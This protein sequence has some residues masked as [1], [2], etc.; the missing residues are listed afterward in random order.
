VATGGVVWYFFFRK[1]KQESHTCVSPSKSAAEMIAHQASNLYMGNDLLLR[2]DEVVMEPKPIANGGGGQ[3]FLGQFGTRKVALKENFASLGC[4]ATLDDQKETIREAGLL[5]KLRHPNVVTF[6]G[7]WSPDRNTGDNDTSGLGARV[8]LVLEYCENGDLT[9]QIQNTETS[10]ELRRK[11][12]FQIAD[13]LRFLHDREPPIVHRDIKPGNILLDINNNAKVADFGTSKQQ[14]ERDLT[15]CVG[16]IA[17]M[18]PEILAD[19]SD[20]DDDKMKTVADGTK[21]DVF[22][23]AV[24]VTYILSGRRPHEGKN[25]KQIFLMV[26][27]RNE[28]TPIPEEIKDDSIVDLIQRMWHDQP[29]KRPSFQQIVEELKVMNFQVSPAPA[30]GNDSEETGDHTM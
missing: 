1:T 4:A 5:V 15:T 14:Q 20:E 19:A 17:Y 26:G 11:W 3:V 22:S 8:L 2:S 28:R 27:M 10:L 12:T 24:M 7:L 16:T 21:W 30:A 25:N 29:E 9:T 23:Y 18:P 6:Y 13:A